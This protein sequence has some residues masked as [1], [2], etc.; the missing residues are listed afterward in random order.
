MKHVYTQ[1]VRLLEHPSRESVLPGGVSISSDKKPL[2][3][4]PHPQLYWP[5]PNKDTYRYNHLEDQLRERFTW[6][7]RVATQC[8]VTS[9][10]KLCINVFLHMTSL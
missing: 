2:Y 5:E 9:G 4:H 1:K 3:A 8:V 6:M 7:T 10:F